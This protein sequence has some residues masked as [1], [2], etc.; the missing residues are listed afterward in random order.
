MAATMCVR[1]SWRPIP[2]A[3][4]RSGGFTLTEVLMVT[5]I[6]AVVMAI[7]LPSMA[8][9][10]GRQRIGTFAS[11]LLVT[12]QLARNDAV[13]RGGTTVVCKSANGLQCADTGQWEQGWIVFQDLDQ[14]AQRDPDEP[15]I[16]R[17]DSA[18]PGLSIRGNTPVSRYVSYTALGSARLASGALQAGTITVCATSGSERPAPRQVVLAASGRARIQVGAASA[19]P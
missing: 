16:G 18:S 12:L 1:L 6:A 17:Q 11:A 9:M 3:P 8:A 4:A 7:A 10:L 2:K 13:R 14:D 5:A 19:C 15:L